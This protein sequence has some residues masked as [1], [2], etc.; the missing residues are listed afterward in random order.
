M[1]AL[2]DTITHAAA[3]AALIVAIVEALRGRIASIDGWRVLVVAAGVALA[4]AALFAP[5]Y[6]LAEL[7]AGLRVAVV[8]WLLAVGG[9]AWVAKIVAARASPA[10]FAASEAPTRRDVP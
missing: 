9:D 4:L 8:A 3:Y 1:I 2:Q 5:A 6:S 7:L 10:A